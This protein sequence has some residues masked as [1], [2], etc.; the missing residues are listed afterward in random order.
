[1]V[2]K[3]ADAS[4]PLLADALSRDKDEQVRLAAEAVMKQGQ[5]SD[6]QTAVHMIEACAGGSAPADAADVLAAVE[7]QALALGLPG[8]PARVSA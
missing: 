6:I 2:K 4:V 7:A 1:M 8:P 5:L 3:V